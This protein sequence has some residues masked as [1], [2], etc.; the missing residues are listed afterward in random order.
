MFAYQHYDFVPD[1]LVLGKGLTSGYQAASAVLMRAEVDP[2]KPEP[3]DEPIHIHTLGGN[4][5]ACA[6]ALAVIE[7]IEQ[8]GLVERTARVGERFREDLRKRLADAP[9]VRAVRGCGLLIGIE[10]DAD[11]RPPK[12]VERAAIAACLQRGL[13]VQGSSGPYAV[14]VLH[15][16]LIVSPAELEEAASTLRESLVSL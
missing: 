6:A 9:R 2:F 11:G 4:P 14:I 1:M 15:P 13:M 3:A 10:L 7:T 5:L 16:P 8:E 12:E